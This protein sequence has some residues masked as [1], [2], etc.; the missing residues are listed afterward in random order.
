MPDVSEQRKKAEQYRF[1]DIHPNLC[2]GTASDRYAGWIGQIYSES[3]GNQIKTRKRRLKDDVFEER[4]LPIDSTEDYF[5]H[6]AVLEI[7]FTF[8]RPLLK[9]DKTPSNNF[10]VLEK[11]AT[12]APAGARFFLKAP[13]QFFART[14]RRSGERGVKYIKNPSFLDADA[15]TKQFHLPAK[16]LLG[17][18]LAGIIFEQAYQRRSES[19][20]PG[21]FIAELDGFFNSIPHDVQAHLEVRSPHLLVPAYFAWLESRG[22]GLVFSHWTWL[23]SLREQWQRSGEH[24]T[25]ADGNAVTRL[26]TPLRMPYAD[27]YARAYPFDI[28][29]PEL[30]ETPQ[31]RNMVL[32]VT[33]LAIR[34][35]LNGV[36]LN[37][38]SNNRAWGNAPDLARTIA[39][40]ILDEVEKRAKRP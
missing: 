2:F 6:F 15:Y 5:D 13:Q 3:F 33:A 37:I 34:A 4:T 35:A 18:R 10:F 26:L 19:P 24:F 16:K 39:F 14:L 29:V 12:S 20:D 36:V 27:A 38:I 30:S 32:D 7:D 31:A 22:L 21:D 8:Y 11:Y 17:D 25:A 28:T 40:R 23:P 1:H 9:V